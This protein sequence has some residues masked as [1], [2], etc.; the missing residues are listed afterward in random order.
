[1]KKKLY[2][3]TSVWNQLE[4][5]DRPDWKVTA[6]LFFANVKTGHYEPYISSVV[7]DEIGVTTDK[8]L[9]ARLIDHVNRIRPVMLEFNDEALALAE[10]YIASEFNGTNS[11]QVYND[12]RHVAVATINDLKH[13]VSFNCR[14]LV[15]DRRI[16][17]FNAVNI[18]NGYD[19]VVDI[20][21]PDKF[22]IK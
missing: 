8:K 10:K 14:H 22:V 19:L 6:E 11:K 2:I 1:M 16:D 18:H 9:Q 21:T 20:A 7:I 12:C 3:E 4:H 5:D 17:G 13:I 15:N